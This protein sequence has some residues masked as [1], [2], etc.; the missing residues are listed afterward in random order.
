MSR[1]RGLDEELRACG[2]TFDQVDEEHQVDE[3]LLHAWDVTFDEAQHQQ[4][5]RKLLFNGKLRT[6]VKILTSTFP[7]R[8]S[9]KVTACLE[10]AAQLPT[11]FGSGD[12]QWHQDSAN[13]RLSIVEVEDRP[14]KRWE[15]PV[16]CPAI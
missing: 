1:T 12:F 13:P 2:V 15:C 7:S 4:F 8:R 5:R 10:K 6:Q 14:C 11:G 9:T 16:S 3:E